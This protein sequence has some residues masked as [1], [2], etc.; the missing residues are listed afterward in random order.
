MNKL[1][2]KKSL[3]IGLF[4]V[5]EFMEETMIAA[6]ARNGR[7][8]AQIDRVSE[9]H[10]D[11]DPPTLFQLNEFIYPFHEIVTTYGIPSYKEVNPTTFNMV[12]FPFLFGVMFGDVGHGLILLLAASFVCLAKERVAA[13]PG[14]MPFVKARYLLLLM[15]LFATYCGLIYNDMMAIPLDLFGTCYS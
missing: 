7:G 1:K 9:S 13:V 12:T 11:I 2:Q 6:N 3:L 8:A 14:L 5:P 15:G 10:S 4:W